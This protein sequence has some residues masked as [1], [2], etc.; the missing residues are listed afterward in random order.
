MLP[1]IGTDQPGDHVEDGGLAG[2]VRAEQTDRLA[3]T[4][5]ERHILDDEAALEGAAQAARHEP[6]LAR[7]RPSAAARPRWLRRGVAP[8]AVRV[9][10]AAIHVGDPAGE[11]RLRSLRPAAAA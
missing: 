6:V 2:A 10:G 1:A 8:D 9:H 5:R 7:A 11:R 3:A 4:E